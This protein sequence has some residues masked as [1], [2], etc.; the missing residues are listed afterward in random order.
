MSLC[1]V[2]HNE[3]TDLSLSISSGKQ[4]AINQT[5]FILFLWLHVFIDSYWVVDPSNIP[6]IRWAMYVGP[7][8]PT[9]M[10]QFMIEMLFYFDFCKLWSMASC[11]LWVDTLCSSTSNQLCVFTHTAPYLSLTLYHTL[12]NCSWKRRKVF[13]VAHP[14]P[15]CT[16]SRTGKPNV[17]YE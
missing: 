8:P 11:I 12:L 14:H 2:A 17:Q 4:E 5:F 7:G 13:K 6:L 1:A 16:L 10:R 9:A 3:C 15:V